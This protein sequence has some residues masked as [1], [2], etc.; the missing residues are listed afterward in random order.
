MK[1][2]MILSNFLQFK[3]FTGQILDKT[4][5]YWKTSFMPKTFDR[6]P[7]LPKVRR[8]IGRDTTELL[9]TALALLGTAGLVGIMIR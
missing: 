1:F 7:E 8:R 4:I 2:G 6:A 3:S 9:I 5:I